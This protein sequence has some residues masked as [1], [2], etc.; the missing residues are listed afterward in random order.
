[1]TSIISR[2]EDKQELHKSAFK[3]DSYT[4]STISQ[5]DITP[6]LTP[7]RLQVLLHHRLL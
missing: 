6:L 3:S 2:S 7:E 4:L 5:L 1:M